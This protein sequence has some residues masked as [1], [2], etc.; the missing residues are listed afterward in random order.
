MEGSTSNLNQDLPGGPPLDELLSQ[1][2]SAANAVEQQRYRDEVI[3][4]GPAAIER[5]REERWLCHRPLSMFAS[6]VVREVGRHHRDLAERALVEA[7]ACADDRASKHIRSTAEA[8]DI[9]LP[10]VVGQKV[11]AY[12][13]P[14]GTHHLVADRYVGPDVPKGEIYLS[15]CGW[16]FEGPWAREHLHLLDTPGQTLCGHCRNAIGRA[17]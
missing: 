4:H 17:K 5:L 6:V 13:D 2:R 9:E 7:L 16:V 11:P 10:R 3:A 12:M 14:S 1:V 15:E 8:L